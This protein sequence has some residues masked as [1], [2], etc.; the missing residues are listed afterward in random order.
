[1]KKIILVLVLFVCGCATTFRCD[2]KD[3]NVS[4]IIRYN[5]E[6]R[7]ATKAQVLNSLGNPVSQEVYFPL[8][9][10]VETLEYDSCQCLESL[11]LVLVDDIV[12]D[13]GYW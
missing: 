12:T 6:L 1:M 10:K 3:R 11:H 9:N 7:G 5:G 13:I 2:E 4:N 8:C